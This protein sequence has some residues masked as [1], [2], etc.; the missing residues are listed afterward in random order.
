MTAPDAGPPEQAAESFADDPDE[1]MYDDEFADRFAEHLAGGQPFI[2][3]PNGSINTGS[4]YGGQ[5]VKNVGAS[6]GGPGPRRVEAFEGPITEAEIL[7]ARFG[8]A[9]PHW[10]RQA[11]SELSTRILFLTGEPG[12][13]RRTAA[14]N[15]LYRHSGRSLDLRALDSG[16]DLSSWRPTH[17]K[18][19]GYLVNGL[20]P[21]QAFGPAVL[22]NLR[23]KLKDA[24]ACM[25]IVL[26][27]E[28]SRL[29]GLTRDLHVEPIRCTPPAPRAVFDARLAATVP[30]EQRRNRLE[31]RFGPLLTS[32]LTPGQVAE[33]VAEVA[34]GGDD[35]PDPEALRER[36]SYLAEDEVPELLDRLRGDPD[37]LAFLLAIS[38][39]EGLDHRIVQDEA[40]RLV[41]LADGRLDAVLTGE[42]EGAKRSTRPNPKFVLR[43]PLEELLRMVRAECRPPEIRNTSGFN[44]TVEPV[45]FTRHRQSETVLRH[46]WRQYGGSSELLTEWMD[47]IPGRDSDL[48]ER[49]GRVMGLAASWGGGRQALRHIETLAGS[50]RARSRSAAAYA[51]GIAAQEPVLA[52]EVKF[53]LGQWSRRDGKYLRW[54]VARA[55]G[56]DFGLARPEVALT[57]LHRCYRGRDGDEAGVAGEVGRALSALFAGGNKELVFSA[58]TTWAERPGGD[59][60]FVLWVFPS[61]MYHSDSWFRQQLTTVTEHRATILALV[62]QLLDD[63]RHFRS[64]CRALL[65]WC[66]IAVWN[67]EFRPA[68]E[69]LLNA[70]AQDMRHGVFAL[71][72]EID[73]YDGDLAG[74]HIARQALEDWRHGTP[75]T[76]RQAAN[77]SYPASPDGGSDVH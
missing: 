72:V 22:A 49:V 14:L 3:A 67:D 36:L 35:G 4:V 52:S 6:V 13:G 39:F 57:L 11:L 47:T 46:L 17:T 20:L 8:F 38:V 30:S 51:L 70:L 1:E 69:A 26:P 71:F 61:L 21:Q 60:D 58:I 45:H 40:R 48:A 44:Y 10:F 12:S 16:V 59:P 42:D 77:G 74:R 25:V 53:R 54:T 27:N 62:R 56:T 18:V 66:S 31:D 73:R 29:R 75:R 65:H 50:D 76:N 7:D 43:R 2:Y 55:C 63:E 28:P 64:I 15:L 34:A 33:L 41:A 32:D 68:V 23:A 37:G 5:R 9:E 24:G 19:R